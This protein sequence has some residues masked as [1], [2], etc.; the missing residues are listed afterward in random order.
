MNITGSATGGSC[1]V[2]MPSDLH[3]MHTVTHEGHKALARTLSIQGSRL[4][5]LSDSMKTALLSNQNFFRTNTLLCAA[6]IN[7]ED[8]LEVSAHL[9]CNNY[10]VA[11]VHECRHQHHVQQ[12][13]PVMH[14]PLSISEHALSINLC[15]L[16]T[17]KS[18]TWLDTR[19]QLQLPA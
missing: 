8:V 16:V 7:E 11:L 3:L 14:D 13:Q 4:K 10:A 17:M 12:R 5:G 2:E 19:G 6:Y 9:T 18:P 1:D 15:K